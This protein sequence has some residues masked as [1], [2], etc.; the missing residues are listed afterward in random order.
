MPSA[1]VRTGFRGGPPFDI[2]RYLIGLTGDDMH[3]REG[4]R[5]WR[6]GL[7]TISE[8]TQGIMRWVGLIL[9][10]LTLATPTQ[11]R[12]ICW[13]RE[14]ERLVDTW[15]DSYVVGVLAISLLIFAFP[16]QITAWVSTYFSASTLIVILNIVLLQRVFGVIASP[17]RS[18]WGGEAL[19]EIGPDICN[20]RLFQKDARDCDGTNRDRFRAAVCI[21]EPLSGS[22][23]R[24]CALAIRPLSQPFRMRTGGDRLRA[25]L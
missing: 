14:E 6:R 25:S 10:C 12:Y 9:Y 4:L 3:F 1:L 18:L 22:G 24:R 17:E 20:N 8:A 13:G 21:F 11:W 5:H 2:F 16:H 15:T 7:A 19:A 23:W